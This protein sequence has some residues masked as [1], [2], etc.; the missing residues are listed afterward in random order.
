MKVQHEHKLENGHCIEIGEATWEGGDRS[1]RSRYPTSTGGFNHCNSPE[2][3]MNDITP[4]LEFIA[5]KDEL[6]VAQCRRI[7]DALAASISRRK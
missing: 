7:I 3:P 2:V 1:V 5:E 6:E 4:M